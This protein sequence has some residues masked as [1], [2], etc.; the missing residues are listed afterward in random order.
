VTDRNSLAVSVTAD[1]AEFWVGVPS[2]DGELLVEQLSASSYLMFGGDATV[3]ASQEDRVLSGPM[4]G[5]ISYCPGSLD[6]NFACT[7]PRVDC[8]SE[9]HRL[10]FSRR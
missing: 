3:E 9:S 5:V 4:N 2:L 7:V 8:N 10:I 1:T 6:A